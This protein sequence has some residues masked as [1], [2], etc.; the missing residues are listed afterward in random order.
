MLT[1]PVNAWLI[2]TD[3]ETGNGHRTKMSPRNPNVPLVKSQYHIIDP[4]NPGRALDDGVE[5][6]LHIGGRA[7]Y[8]A[9]HLGCCRLMLQ[10]LTQFCIPFL[11]LL[12]QPDILD[13]NDGLVG[14]GL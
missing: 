11:Q 12:K 6:G 8:D 9:E 1:H 14:E 2:C 5:D 4:T 3:L 13:G 7:A 10:C